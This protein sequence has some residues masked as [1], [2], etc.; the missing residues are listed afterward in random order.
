[1]DQQTFLKIIS[2]NF[3]N[4]PKNKSNQ[5]KIFMSSTFTGNLKKKLKINFTK[6]KN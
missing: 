1:M 6:I 2:G 3:Q 4:I 5:V